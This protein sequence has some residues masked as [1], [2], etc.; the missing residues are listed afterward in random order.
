MAK[1]FA[2][3]S[4]NGELACFSHVLLNAIDIYEKG[5]DVRIIIEGQSTK[6]L[7]EF[8]VKDAPFSALFNKVREKGLIDCVCRACAAKMGTLHDAEEMGLN[9]AG[10]L[11]GHPSILKYIEDGYQV[12]LF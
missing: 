7:P 11:Q 3:F 10:Y 8:R 5:Y 9:I 6:L 12:L 1:K 4:F 2:L